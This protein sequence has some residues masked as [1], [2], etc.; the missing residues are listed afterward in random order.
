MAGSLPLFKKA[1]DGYVQCAGADSRGALDELPYW[2]DALIRLGRAPEAV[3]ML[4]A[5]LPAWRRVLNGS[6][7]QSEMLYFLARGYIALGR[8]ADA[9]VAA[10]ELLKLLTGKLAGDDRSIGTAH[11]VMG[12]ALAGQRRY[13]EAAPHAKIAVDLLV[14]SAVSSYA[15]LLGEEAAD[16][17]RK[18]QSAPH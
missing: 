9:E 12:E 2:A 18:V 7:D 3:S 11:L 8:F 15:R 16:L 10:A 13:P 17:D 5:A 4:E 1:Y 14:S 6:T